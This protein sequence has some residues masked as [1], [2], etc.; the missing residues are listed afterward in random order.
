M[1][2]EENMVAF[3]IKNA[4]E[5]CKNEL[6]LLGIEIEVPKTP[7]VELRF[8]EVYDILKKNGKDIYGEDLDSEAEKILWNYVKNKYNVDFYFFNRFPHKIKPFYVMEVDEEPEWARS[9]DLNFRGMEREHRYE[10][11][12]KNIKEREMDPKNVEWFT[13]FFKYGAPPHGGFAIGIE[14]FT[15][16]LLGLANIRE[17][18]LFPRDPERTTP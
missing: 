6:K 13:K 11:I 9:V 3:A 15:Q 14:R 7:F 8:P 10:K 4:K 12:L 2:V 17:A 16:V 5:K 18:T 1:K